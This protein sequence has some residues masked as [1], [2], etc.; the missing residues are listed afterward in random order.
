VATAIGQNEISSS[1]S[2]DTAD[3]GIGNHRFDFLPIESTLNTAVR[4]L[5]MS[6]QRFSHS[7]G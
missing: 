1:A 7:C 5:G 3:P 6:D 4:D 2:L